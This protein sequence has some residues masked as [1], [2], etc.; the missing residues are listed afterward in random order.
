MSRVELMPRLPPPPVLIPAPLPS[1][2]PDAAGH[3]LTDVWATA[4]LIGHELIKLK[5]NRPEVIH[6]L[7]TCERNKAPVVRAMTEAKP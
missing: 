7:V 2:D 5:A 3:A 1:F 6:F 4:M